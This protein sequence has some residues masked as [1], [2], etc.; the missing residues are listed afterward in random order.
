MILTHGPLNDP[1][2]TSASF[3]HS[4]QWSRQQR[5][6]H[7]T[8]LEMWAI[9][10]HGKYESNPG[11][12]NKNMSSKLSSGLEIHADDLCVSGIHLHFLRGCDE[13]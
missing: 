4:L 3:Q 11:C 12:L 2:I 8:R 13:V 10:S 6:H 9:A 5:N 7:A 1:Y